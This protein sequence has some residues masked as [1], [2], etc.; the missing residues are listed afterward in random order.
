MGYTH[1]WEKNEG[2]KLIIKTFKTK[3]LKAIEVMGKVVNDNSKLLAG[4]DG[5]GKPTVTK[6]VI[7]F[8]GKGED[9]SHETFSVASNW[10]GSFDF[11]KTARKPY[12]IVVVACLAVLKHFCGNAVRISSDG[13]DSSEGKAYECS[14]LSLEAGVSLA[15]L[16]IPTLDTRLE[17]I[18]G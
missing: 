6:D 7:R 4:W 15:K 14:R 9:N 11:C 1:Y 12:D 5:T 18:F 10:D 16:Y 8:N 13:F 17:K 2:S 3:L